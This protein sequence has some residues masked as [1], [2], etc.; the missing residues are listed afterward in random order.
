MWIRDTH[1]YALATHSP[2]LT[3]THKQFIPWSHGLKLQLAAE[4]LDRFKTNWLQEHI[5]SAWIRPMH[6]RG[7]PVYPT[8]DKCEEG[9]HALYWTCAFTL[10]FFQTQT[11]LNSLYPSF[12]ATFSVFS[13]TCLS[14]VFPPLS[15]VS[16][17]VHMSFVLTLSVAVWS[18][19][20]FGAN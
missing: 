12:A 2:F 19:C 16:I 14:S 6:H 17:H 18:H 8:E 3:Y 15:S 9:D 20:M 11:C 4:A 5:S 7:R 10:F 13:L 1:T